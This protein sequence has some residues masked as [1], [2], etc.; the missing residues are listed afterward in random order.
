MNNDQLRAERNAIR[1]ETEAMRLMESTECDTNPDQ[2]LSEL[3]TLADDARVEASIAKTALAAHSEQHVFQLLMELQERMRTTC[4]MC[5][6]KF[7]CA[8]QIYGV[9]CENC[10]KLMHVC[11]KCKRDDWLCLVCVQEME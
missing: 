7:R 4:S 9:S 6:R 3:D 11:K 1:C 8:E 5:C 2:V 10:G